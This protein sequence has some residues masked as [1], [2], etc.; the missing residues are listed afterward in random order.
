MGLVAVALAVAGVLRPAGGTL[1]PPQ[2]HG[3]VGEHGDAFG[4]PPGGLGRGRTMRDI[5]KRSFLT[6]LRSRE[7]QA[8]RRWDGLGFGGGSLL[9]GWWTMKRRRDSDVRLGFRLKT[10]R[11]LFPVPKDCLKEKNGH[12]ERI[13]WLPQNVL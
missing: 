5:F 10:E 6:L 9:R 1:V 12:I 13:K 2:S 7:I 8:G 11:A 3:P 4:N